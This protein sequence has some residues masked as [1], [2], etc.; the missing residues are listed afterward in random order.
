MFGLEV[1]Q[2][3]LIS[4]DFGESLSL[5]MLSLGLMSRLL[6]KLLLVRSIGLLNGNVKV[7]RVRLAAPMNFVDPPSIRLAGSRLSP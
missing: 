7:L 2:T 3:I 4:L 1:V 5:G 6:C